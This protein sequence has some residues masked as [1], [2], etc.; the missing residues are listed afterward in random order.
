MDDGFNPI[1]LVGNSV[2]L[3][4]TIHEIFFGSRKSLFRVYFGSHLVYINEYELKSHEV[5]SWFE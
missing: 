2:K 4:Q 3:G 1:L 5:Q